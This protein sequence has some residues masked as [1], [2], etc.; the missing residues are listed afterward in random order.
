MVLVGSFLILI[1]VGSFKHF[2][3]GIV[4]TALAILLPVELFPVSVSVRSVVCVH[5]VRIV[6]H[7]AILN[8]NDILGVLPRLASSPTVAAYEGVPHSL[9]ILLVVILLRIHCVI[10]WI[11]LLAIGNVVVVVLTLVCVL[12]TNL[13]LP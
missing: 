9:S 13:H 2:V 10:L 6:V 1:I 7:H 8:T 5:I 11:D 12:T 4:V 3:L